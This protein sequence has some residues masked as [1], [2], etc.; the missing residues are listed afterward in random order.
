VLENFADT[1]VGLGRALKVLGSA[2]LLANF[3]TLKNELVK[4][5]ILE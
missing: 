4:V 3:L 2:N 5:V 1:L